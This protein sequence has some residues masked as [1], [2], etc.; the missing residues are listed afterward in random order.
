MATISANGAKG[1]HKF[2]LEVIENST[3]TADNTSSLSFT[4][5]LSPIQT[6]WNWADWGSA[7]SYT[8]NINGTNYTG[9]IPAYD[10]YSTVT[11]KSGSLTVAHNTDG[12]KSINYSF[13]VDDNADQ[14]Y[15]CG[16]ASARGTMA[17]SN[18]PRYATSNQSFKSKT[19]TTITMNWSSDSTIDYI[20]V[21]KD[22]GANWS[23]LDVTDGTSGSYTLK[24]LSANTTYNIKTRVRRKDSQLTTDSSSTEVTTYD[25]PKP[26][27]LAHFTIGDGVVVDVNNPLGRWYRLELISKETWAVIASQEGT[28]NGGVTIGK[29]EDEINLQY[30]SIPDKQVGG[31][32]ARVL[33]ESNERTLDWGGT[34]KIRGNETP[35]VGSLSYKDN[36][37][38]TTAITGN[39]QRI[40]RNNSNLLFTVGSA[41]PKNSASI[42]K[43]EITFAGSTKSRTSTGD[44]DFGKIN[45]SSNSTATLKVTDSR[46]LSSTTQITVTIDNWVLPSALISL[47]RKN[48][49]YSETYLKVDGTVSSLNSK[50]AMTIQ[51]QYKKVTDSNYSSLANLSDN[52][53]ATIELDNNYQWNIKVI[54]KDKLG[55]TTYNLVLD[56]GMPMIFFDRLKTSTGINCIPKYEKSLEADG[57]VISDGLKVSST[58]PSKKEKVWIKKSNNLFNGNNYAFR[59]DYNSG[60][61]YVSTN[62]ASIQSNGTWARTKAT[63]TGLK[64]N[65]PYVMSAN[66][67]K[68]KLS[69]DTISG[70]YSDD[71]NQTSGF[72]YPGYITGKAIYK[73]VSSANGTHIVD[74]YTNWTG[75][76]S[77]GSVIYSNIQLEEGDVVTDYE[78]YIDKKIYIKNGVDAYE[79]V[80][81]LE[82][83]NNQQNYSTNE[84]VIGTWIDGKPLYRKTLSTGALLNTGTLLVPYNIDNLKRILKV[85]GIAYNGS[86]GLLLPASHNNSSSVINVYVDYG[87]KGVAIQTFS[88]RSSYGEGYITIEYTKTTD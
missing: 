21:S 29:S 82:N 41:T 32:Y 80:L 65:T 11:L 25:Y 56:R 46:G 16:D 71:Y 1:H 26:T 24:N 85:S 48:N 19:E 50:N 47:N 5:K 62:E 43:Y 58:E 30:M 4:F 87:G 74:F 76:S 37:S 39:N 83:A 28:Y 54:V 45:L 86:F 63:L 18:I 77:K 72:V 15:T 7:I 6:S 59:N 3:S 52:V 8:I 40:I 34:Y 35:T 60:I 88:D 84:Q 79:E 51:Y 64:P 42:S 13:S 66:V 61:D 10:G 81:N 49:F 73:F 75:N 36:N 55:S 27:S 78:P 9:T 70:F 57:E 33:Y 20:W 53:Q 38:T 12:T 23:A 31:Y 2:T 14:R 68:S 44:L 69:A 22:N 67:D 17:L